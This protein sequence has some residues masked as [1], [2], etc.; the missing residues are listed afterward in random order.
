M[1]C[2]NEEVTY[3]EICN[4]VPCPACGAPLGKPCGMGAGRIRETAHPERAAMASKGGF[5]SS[6]RAISG[7]MSLFTKK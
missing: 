4:K 1:M 2:N 6:K 3:T 7:V 5:A